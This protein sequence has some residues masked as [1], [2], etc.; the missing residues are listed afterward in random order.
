MLA[1]FKS[2]SIHNSNSGPDSTSNPKLAAAFLLAGTAIGSGMISLPM[3]L[4]KFGIIKS[5]CI[6]ISFAVLTYLTALIRADLNINL[7]STATLEEC[8]CY[9]GCSWAGFL[10]NI[11]LKLL[12]FALIAAYLF[13]LASILK[14]L[15]NAPSQNLMIFV[16]SVVVAT[17]F[18]FASE[19]IVNLNKFLFTGLFCAF[20]VLVLKLFGDTHIKFIPQQSEVIELNAWTEIVPIIFT[21]F[22]LQGSIHSVT[23][24]CNNNS[25]KI[26]GACFWGCL[27]ATIVYI[28]W[29][30]AILFVISNSDPDFF[31]LM[32]AGKSTDVGELVKILSQASSSQMVHIIVWIV[33]TLAILT[34]ILGAGLAL[35][36]IFEQEWRGKSCKWKGTRNWKIVGLVIFVPA[37]VSMLI[38][39]AFIKILNFAGVI[40][41]CIAIIIPSIISIKMQQIKKVRYKPLLENR[42]LVRCVM[43]C[44]MLIIALG[45]LDF[46]K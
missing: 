19:L 5:C 40:L 36:D 39:N 46:L 35:I 21:S 16:V 24:I 7:H 4:A 41:A 26:K 14:T 34:S 18:I 11:L 29:T 22:G 12:S 42:V 3:V 10:G 30:A 20:L 27:A 33:S 31:Q 8:G 37:F 45:F 17:V 38:P 6:M 44:G 13:G 28:I 1:R 43:L 9:F 25:S 15:F 2:D 32:V 23:K